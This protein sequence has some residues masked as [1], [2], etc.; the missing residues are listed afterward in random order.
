MV[1]DFEQEMVVEKEGQKENKSEVENILLNNKLKLPT[2]MDKDGN[3]LYPEV[4]SRVDA[5]LSN[6][7]ATNKVRMEYIKNFGYYV[8]GEYKDDRESGCRKKLVGWK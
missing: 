5:Y 2:I 1:F 8:F 3:D 7:D 4:R 6:P